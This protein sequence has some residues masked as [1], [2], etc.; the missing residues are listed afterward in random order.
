MSCKDMRYQNGVLG[1]NP[2]KSR[3]WGPAHDHSGARQ[4]ENKKV[5]LLET[6][7]LVNKS[8]FRWRQTLRLS[9]VES[10]EGSE[11]VLVS[12]RL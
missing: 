2:P 3:G 11:I 12:T 6:E 5:T 7:G 9:K 4:M 8:G 10:Q 1:Y